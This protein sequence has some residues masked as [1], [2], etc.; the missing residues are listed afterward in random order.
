MKD[1]AMGIEAKLIGL[2]EAR[3]FC[4]YHKNDILNNRNSEIKCILNTYK[5]FSSWPKCVGGILGRGR[6]KYI[7]LI[8]QYY[9]HIDANEVDIRINKESIELFNQCYMQMRDKLYNELKVVRTKL[10]VLYEDYGKM[11][12]EFRN[13]AVKC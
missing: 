4:D 10:K 3:L 9:Y 5:N 12:F 2:E 11:N 7:A 8:D 6:F 1:K 13:M